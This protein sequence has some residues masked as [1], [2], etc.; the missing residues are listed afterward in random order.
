MKK[1]I[2]ILLIIFIFS[3]SNE[4]APISLP[5]TIRVEETVIV[6][7]TKIVD[8]IIYLDPTYNPNQTPT[9]TAK[10]TWTPT[11]TPIISPQWTPTPTP[12]NVPTWTPTPTPITN[13]QW[14]PTPTP[15]NV[16]TWTPTPTSTS[17]PINWEVYLNGVLVTPTPTSEPTWTPSPTPTNVPTWTPTATSTPLPPGDLGYELKS[18]TFNYN[19][20][21]IGDIV[22]VGL[23]TDKSPIVDHNQDNDLTDGITTSDDNNFKVLSVTHRKNGNSEISIIGITP[24]G[25]TSVTITFYT[26]RR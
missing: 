17:T 7:V 20:Q 4:V 6:E 26:L 21:N 16:P 12:T 2:T 18:F 11:P 3:C 1:I 9:P 22:T 23:P 15:T 10:A 8:K 13:P 25:S 19:F 24:T 5:E 14:T